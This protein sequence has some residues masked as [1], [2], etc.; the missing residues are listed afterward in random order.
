MR[1]H[2]V[3]LTLFVA[4]VALL[5]ALSA[6]MGMGA[7]AR[8]HVVGGVPVPEPNPL[9]FS[10]ALLN[11]AEADPFQAQFCGATLI[12]PSWVLTAAH[13]VSGPRGVRS[14]SSIQIAVGGADLSAVGPAARLGVAS[15]HV[16]PGFRPLSDGSAQNDIALVRLRS[17]VDTPPALLPLAGDVSWTTGRPTAALAGWGRTDA[18]D[19]SYAAVRL[20]VAAVTVFEQDVCATAYGIAMLPG[21]LCAGNWAGTPTVCNGDSGGPL[22]RLS[23]D[24]LWVLI[25]VT[26]WGPRLCAAP[27]HPPVFASVAFHRRWIDGVLSS[28][29]DPSRSSPVSPGCRRVGNEYLASVRALRARAEA[30]RRARGGAARTRSLNRVRKAAELRD[31]RFDM[32]RFLCAA[33]DPSA[34]PACRR[35]LDVYFRRIRSFTTARDRVTARSG[36]PLHRRQVRARDRAQLVADRAVSSG[37]RICLAS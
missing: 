21:E 24:R 28:R 16:H 32:M 10:A 15:I 2:Q 7:T 30:H 17:S 9:P 13:C 37:I 18:F 29:L 35:S 23:S 4:I 11:S 12:A 5:G 27:G 25:G 19:P 33:E 3:G 26:N 1:S 14:T 22:V 31:R 34:A 8:E 36:T 6:S 20:Q